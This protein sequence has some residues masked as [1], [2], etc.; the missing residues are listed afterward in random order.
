MSLSKLYQE[1]TAFYPGTEL[2]FGD[3]DAKASLL[4]IGEAPGRDEVEQKKPFVGKAGKNL[5]RRFCRR[6][7]FCTGRLERSRRV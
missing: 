7:I 4:L 3:G 1:I 2:V 5:N 6:R